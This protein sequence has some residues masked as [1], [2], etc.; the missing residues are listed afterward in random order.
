MG[1]C[2][3]RKFRSITRTYYRAAMAIVIVFDLT[4]PESFEDIDISRS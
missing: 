4:D 1:Y 2:W 3:T